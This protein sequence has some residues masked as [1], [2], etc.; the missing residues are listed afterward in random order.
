MSGY[1]IGDRVEVLWQGELFAAAIIYIHEVEGA[2][3][4]AYEIDD[5]VGVFLTPEEHGLKLLP[6]RPR[7][8]EAEIAG[9]SINS[10]DDPGNGGSDDT[11]EGAPK[12]P[13]RLDKD[14]K[15]G[16]GPPPVA[17]GGVAA[18]EQKDRGLVKTQRSTCSAVG[19]S[20]VSKK[21]GVCRK[22]GGADKCNISGC[23]TNAVAR[24]VCIKHGANGLC[25]AQGCT[26]NANRRGVCVKHGAKGLC[27]AQGPLA[28]KHEESA[29]STK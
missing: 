14:D 13:P 28:H 19:C 16:G 7:V 29:K 2:C 12:R 5:S 4:A 9:A 10:V 23:S 15:A 21:K 27:S 25:S 24:G 6:A 26:T 18:R 22:H 17:A 11:S 3:D 20:N 1:K 8:A